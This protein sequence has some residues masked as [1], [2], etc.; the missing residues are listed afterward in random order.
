M[1]SNNP[2]LLSAGSGRSLGLQQHTKHP[3]WLGDVF[4]PLCTE[5]LIVQRQLTFDLRMNGVR[6]ADAAGLGE[7]F[8]S[9]RNVDA[10][11]EDLRAL[12]HHCADVHPDAKVHAPIRWQA[13]VSSLEGG[14][15][16]DRALDRGHYASE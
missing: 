5:V 1:F 3:H 11:T 2:C 7:T 16:L 15:A 12:H 14:L 4:D 9:R 6:D 13:N 10:V 8:Q